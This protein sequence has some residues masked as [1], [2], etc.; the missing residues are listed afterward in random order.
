MGKARLG[1]LNFPAKPQ[2]RFHSNSVRGTFTR[3]RPGPRPARPPASPTASHITREESRVLFVL[4]ARFADV[5]VTRRPRFRAPFPPSPA[6]SGFPH[7]EPSESVTLRT[8]VSHRLSISISSC[9]HDFYM[10]TPRVGQ[11]RITEAS[12]AAPAVCRGR[13]NGRRYAA[14]FP[15][16]RDG[17]GGNRRISR[18]TS[19]RCAVVA[20]SA[21]QCAELATAASTALDRVLPS[22]QLSNSSPCYYCP[23]FC[24]RSHECPPLLFLTTVLVCVR[25]DF[26]HYS[27]LLQRASESAPRWTSSLQR[28]RI[29][30]CWRRSSSKGSK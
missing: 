20:W 17:G 4:R 6:A 23:A 27:I 7:G 13:S 16:S 25:R 2:V 14:S 22:R 11:Q 3:A 10:I 19:P 30:D 9:R 5:S 15:N 29:T 12:H 24:I 18:R 1:S 26:V 21:A 8:L 28:A